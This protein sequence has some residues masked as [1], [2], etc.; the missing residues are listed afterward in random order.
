MCGGCVY[1]F[2]VPGFGIVGYSE[3]DEDMGRCGHSFVNNAF[4]VRTSSSSCTTCLRT[5]NWRAETVLRLAF[6]SVAGDS[7][8]EVQYETLKGL[9]LLHSTRS[10]FASAPLVECGRLMAWFQ[11]PSLQPIRM[12]AHASYVAA[13]RCFQHN[14]ACLEHP[15]LQAAAAC[16]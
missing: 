4:V 7:L 1:Y 9:K 14:V 3:G 15:C 13:A 11:L 5:D 12:T 8:A 6:N 10:C 2:Y 16:R